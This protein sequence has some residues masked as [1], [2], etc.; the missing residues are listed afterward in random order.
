[1]GI[2]QGYYINA[3]LLINLNFLLPIGYRASST[4]LSAKEMS[5]KEADI[6]KEDGT[7]SS[8][9]TTGK[10]NIHH[11]IIVSSLKT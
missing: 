5:S 6:S 3:V 10:K 11:K 2:D 4:D 1:M 9:S 8:I 7:I